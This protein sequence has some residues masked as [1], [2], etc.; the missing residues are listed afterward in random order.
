ME[1]LLII[2]RKERC[3]AVKLSGGAEYVRVDLHSHSIADKQ[4]KNEQW[5]SREEF[6]DNYIT[7]LEKQNIKIVAIT[8]HNK[9]DR[10]EYCMLREKGRERDILI[11]P[12]V[13]I[14]TID[15]KRGVHFL[16][17]FPPETGECEGNEPQCRIEKFITMMFPEGGLDNYGNPKISQKKLDQMV[18][19]LEK[20][21]KCRQYMIIPAHVDNDK[22][23]FKECDMA[24]KRQY[25]NKDWMRKRI[26]AF[27]GINESSRKAYENEVSKIIAEQGGKKQVLIPAYIEA[28]DP[29]ELAAVGSRYSYV[30]IGE[31]S[32]EALY[33]ALSQHEL[34]V[35]PGEVEK[36]RLP[37]IEKV[38]FVTQQGLADVEIRFN[39]GLNNFIGIRGSGKSTIIEGIRYA[40]ELDAQ[41][42]NEYKDGLLKNTWDRA[43]K[44]L[45]RLLIGLEK[46]I[47]LKEYMDNRLKCI[48]KMNLFRIK[49][50]QFTTYCVLWTERLTR[51]MKEPQLQMEFIDQYIRDDLESIRQK[52]AEKEEEIK[53][54]YSEIKRLEERVEKKEEYTERLATVTKDIDDYKRLAIADKLQLEAAYKKDELFL[55]RVKKTVDEIKSKS[56]EYESD[57]LNILGSISFPKS[58][59]NQDLF[60]RLEESFKTYRRELEKTLKVINQ[61]NDGFSKECTEIDKGFV[62]RK[63]GIEEQIAAI[64]RKMAHIQELSVDDYAKKI[65]EKEKYQEAFKQIEKYEKE[66]VKKKETMARMLEQIQKLWHQ[67]FQIRVSKAEEINRSENFIKIEIHYKGDKEAFRHKLDSLLSGTNI[68]YD[69]KDMLSNSFNDGIELFKALDE[70]ANP[71]L[72]FL[73]E[74]DL[75]KIKQR[76]KANWLELCLFR[77]PDKIK[78]FYKEKPIEQLSLGERASA[79]L[80]LLL[81][82][83][84]NPLLMD[85]PEDDLDNQMIYEGL[86]KEL[87]SLKGKRQVIFATHNSNIPV[88]EIATKVLFVRMNRK[89]TVKMGSIDTRFFQ[90]SIVK[91][92]EGGRD[93]FARRRFMKMDVIDLLETIESG[94]DAKHNLRKYLPVR[95]RWRR[96]FLPLPIVRGAR[97][98]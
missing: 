37:R 84:N 58:E 89:I 65:E 50:I 75:S 40:F 22:G 70:K 25:I 93:A 39:S 46:H 60:N 77:V 32:F 4:F 42:D 17:V 94:E 66:L 36:E 82:T 67:L 57:I 69:K 8:N 11:L 87:L 78:L 55:K 64:K 23:W 30:K 21:L 56:S 83:D 68:R 49:T 34:R 53:I 35:L 18:D 29:K 27:Q 16:C 85:Q 2:F 9:F 15:G 13:E 14:S 48:V 19:V 5:K 26:M 59:H 20:E 3:C 51:K 62:E 98:L 73:N 96:R 88:L 7:Q 74:N 81:K 45:L 71:Q 31:L 79:L 92:M 6:V 72:H 97:L 54:L 1:C 41:S 47:K 91:I 61:L 52:I 80:M 38:K 63:E 90:D 10:E 44:L 95:M 24:V 33:F 28:S 12:G 43:V 86:V 76:L